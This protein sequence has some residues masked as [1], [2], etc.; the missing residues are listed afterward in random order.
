MKANT[1][2]SSDKTPKKTSTRKPKEWTL[3]TALDKVLSEAHESELKPAFMKKCAKPLAFLC[4]SFQ[5]T[6]VQVIIIAMLI[7]AGRPLSWKMM[8]NYL[9]ISRLSMMVYN[10]DAEGLVKR[11]WCIKKA[12]N[13]MGGLFQGYAL[14]YGVVTAIRQNKVFL[15]TPIDNLSLQDFVNRVT[16][17]IQNCEHDSEMRFEDE[18]G[19]MMQ[20]VEAN[21]QLPLCSFLHNSKSNDYSKA[22]FL[23]IVSDYASWGNT[24]NEGLDLSC[25][26]NNLPEDFECGFLRHEF[27]RGSHE[28][29]NL[30]YIEHKCENGIADNTTYMLT[31]KA[32]EEFLED[33]KIRTSKKRRNRHSNNLTSHAKITEK[34]LY[35]NESE[36]AQIQQLVSM[37]GNEQ[38]SNIQARL[39]EM[40]MRKGFA[41]LFYGAPGTGKTESVL[42]ISRI[43]GRDLMQV[44]IAGMRD[45]YVGESE[46][47][48]KKVFSSY[49]EAC[50]DAR[51][52]SKPIPILFFN[53]ADGIFSKRTEN[54][55]RSVEKM[56]NAM[57]NIILQEIENLD[58]ILI[59]T[60]NLTTNLD[61]AFERRFIY[62]VEFHKP[63]TSVK[64]KIWKS[65]L[66]HIS[67]TDAT[68]LAQR[69]DFSGGQIENIVR[70]S[71]VN[72]ILTGNKSSLEQL[73]KFC[74]AESLDD[75]H[76][77]Q[78]ISGFSVAC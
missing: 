49:R 16:S 26:D 65:M 46:K 28:F 31:R 48:I 63:G 4:E 21:Q 57:Q 45:K 27:Q 77:C 66:S 67:E 17:R 73:D 32:K 47:N 40:G 53:E 58:G 51:A 55:D 15:P 59:A 68:V 71:A 9:G 25:I 2:S 35:F 41:C 7:D 54:I 33:Y 30:G 22:V 8:G 29:F 43:T 70:K 78:R 37:L 1:E 6:E 3:I 23:Y 39:E 13:D 24:D 61:K 69:Y 74:Q 20:V 11:R 62:K 44:D 72:Y 5:M 76:Q 19:W 52:C 36:D 38:F 18:I 60:T 50:E 10:D 56:D 14:E 64:A 34:Q 12:A 75:K 42:Q